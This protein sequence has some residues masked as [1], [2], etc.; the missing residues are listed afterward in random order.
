[1]PPPPKTKLCTIQPNEYFV[2][3]DAMKEWLKRNIP[4]ARVIKTWSVLGCI[5]E[6]P[7]PVAPEKKEKK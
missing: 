4:G 3:E 5:V 2:N 1:M 6:C 7:V